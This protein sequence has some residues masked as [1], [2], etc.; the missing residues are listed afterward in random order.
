MQAAIYKPI[1][2]AGVVACIGLLGCQR[3]HVNKSDEPKTSVMSQL[4][5]PLI[6]YN[7]EQI[8]SEKPRLKVED[9]AGFETSSIH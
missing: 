5:S 1:C 9:D 7:I 2:L 8:A 6:P 3:D 4:S